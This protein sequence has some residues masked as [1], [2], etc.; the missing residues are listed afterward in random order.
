MADEKVLE[1]QRWVNRK[2]SGV[3]GY[4][5]CAEDGRTG[6]GTMRALTMGLQHELGISPVVASLSFFSVAAPG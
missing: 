4:T 3:N 2:Y 1:A 6:W 5:R